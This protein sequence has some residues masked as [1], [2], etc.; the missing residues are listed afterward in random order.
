MHRK[1]KEQLI[2]AGIAV[3]ALGFAL[4]PWRNQI[5]DWLTP[6]RPDLK[7]ALEARLAAEDE[8]VLP[9]DTVRR[10]RGNAKTGPE[11]SEMLAAHD[12]QNVTMIGFM[13]ALDQYEDAECFVLMPWLLYCR[14][15]EAPPLRDQFLI[16]LTEP[17]RLVADLVVVRGKLALNSG[18]G[19]P[20]FYSISEAT[21]MPGF[22]GQ[23]ATPVIVPEEHR[24]LV[25]SHG[26][27]SPDVATS[28]R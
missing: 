15:C 22:E 16:E 19:N 14:T 2:L 8:N 26:A 18:P 7:D 5:A 24:H 10:T 12:D 20:F 4:M 25:D 23:P 1:S 3:V 9:W 6:P 13:V 17:T 21:V 28:V 27:D 11:F